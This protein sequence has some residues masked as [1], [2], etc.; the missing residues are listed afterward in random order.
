M[1]PISILCAAVSLLALLGSVLI[2]R[3][4]VQVTLWNEAVDGERDQDSE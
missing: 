4:N 3:R 1:E 2:Y